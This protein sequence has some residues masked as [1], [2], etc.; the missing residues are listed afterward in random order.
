MHAFCLHGIDKNKD[1]KE[2]MKVVDNKWIEDN[3]E[4]GST[5]IDNAKHL[6]GAVRLIRRQITDDNAAIY[7]LSAFCLM[8]LGT[9]NN[10]VLETELGEMYID[11]MKTFYLNL[12]WQNNDFWKGVF[13]EFN[14]NQ[15]VNAY[16]HN[17]GTMLKSAAVLEIH[18][19]ELET[20]K[21]KY[22]A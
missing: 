20:I 15:Y 14:N 7:L 13:D 2:I 9:N 11:G 5:Q 10:K 6:Y 18:K 16:F 4:T 12:K 8:F 1:W 3:S 17:N 19:L 22:T 21:N